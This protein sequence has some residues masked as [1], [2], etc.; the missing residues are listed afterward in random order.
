MKA[1]QHPRRQRQRAAVL[2]HEIRQLRHHEGDENRHQSRARHGEERRIDERLLHAIAQALRL[3]E[4]LY[5]PLQNLR[6]SAARLAGRD[7]VHVNGRE[8]FREFAQRLREAAPIDQRLVQ[9]ARHLLHARMFQALLQN[10]QAFIERHARLEQMRELFGED[11]QLRVR[12]LEPLRCGRSHG[13]AR[14]GVR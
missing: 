9:R 13:G 8:D 1:D 10:G 3:H 11:E 14:A 5:E 7:Q 12:N 6:Q 2:R 4:M